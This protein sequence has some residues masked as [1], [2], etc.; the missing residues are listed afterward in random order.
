MWLPGTFGVKERQRAN[1]QRGIGKMRK[2]EEIQQK[3]TKRHQ[4]G[5]QGVN[6]AASPGLGAKAEGEVGQ[7]WR[8][9]HRINL[10][11]TMDPER[12]PP[13]PGRKGMLQPAG[14]WSEQVPPAPSSWGW[15]WFWLCWHG[16]QCLEWGALGF[17][18]SLLWALNLG[19]IPSFSTQLL[20]SSSRI[21]IDPLDMVRGLTTVPSCLAGKE[22]TI[23][24]TG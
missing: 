17:S 16:K 22:M 1:Q 2:D 4:A 10:S 20:A 3:P 19:C 13:N 18:L 8:S 15:W 24:V 12:S 21:I 6:Q 14:R 11:Q 5:K 9:F 7:I 23:S